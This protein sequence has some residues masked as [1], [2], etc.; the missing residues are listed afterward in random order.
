MPAD[1]EYLVVFRTMESRTDFLPILCPYCFPPYMYSGV[2]MVCM[3]LSYHEV[4]VS[5]RVSYVI[6]FRVYGMTYS[7]M[8]CWFKM[9]F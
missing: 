1:D 3:S 6:P 2:V 5:F 7:S 9:V 8:V 4:Q